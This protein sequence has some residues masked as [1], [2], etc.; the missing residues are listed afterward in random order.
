MPIF[1][2]FAGVPTWPTAVIGVRAGGAAARP[3][4]DRGKQSPTTSRAPVLKL[5]ESN[6]TQKIPCIGY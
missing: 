6:K 3:R 2:A 4:N 1:F 5:A